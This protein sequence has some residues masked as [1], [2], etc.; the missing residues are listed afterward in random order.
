MDDFKL[1]R[2]IEHLTTFV[3]NAKRDG[4]KHNYLRVEETEKII[5]IL[6]DKS[7][8]G[9]EPVEPVPNEILNG[10]GWHDMYN[11]G[12][13]GNQLRTLANFCDVC[14]RPVKKIGAES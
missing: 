3:A 4:R 13:C 14:G 5:A 11:C 7:P 6:V 8:M 1:E 10:L 2:M 9:G 12:A